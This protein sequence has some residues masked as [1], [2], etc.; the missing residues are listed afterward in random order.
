MP[1]VLRRIFRK[2]IAKKDTRGLL[3]IHWDNTLEA[4]TND[5]KQI[6]VLL[7]A[8]RYIK[9]AFPPH[10]DVILRQINEQL[11][12]L[13]ILRTSIPDDLERAHKL[14]SAYHTN[15]SSSLQLLK[16]GQE[17]GWQRRS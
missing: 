7:N 17:Q 11:H 1:N 14:L 16:I 10:A 9:Q 8:H 13:D 15:A 2:D 4:V 6:V 5:V 12:N 3:T